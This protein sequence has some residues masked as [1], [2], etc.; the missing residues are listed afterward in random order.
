MASRQRQEQLLGL[1]HDDE[2]AH[3]EKAAQVEVEQ[4]TQVMVRRMALRRRRVQ[5]IGRPTTGHLQVN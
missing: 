1:L 3:V 2:V 5:H 4:A